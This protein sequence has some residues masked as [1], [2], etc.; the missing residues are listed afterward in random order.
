MKKFVWDTSALINI[1]E[2][3][4]SGY[5]PGYSLMKDLSDGWIPGPYQNIYPAIAVFEVN[6]TVSRMH[7]EG[8]KILRDYYI[9]NESSFIYSIDQQLIYKCN[10]LVV[11]DGFSGLRG[12]DLIFACIAYL[13]KA[14]LVTKDKDFSVIAH[15]VQVIDLNVS[16][17][18][19]KYREQIESGVVEP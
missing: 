6:A 8:K 16:I 9:M 10:E 11:L 17:H 18:S 15:H 4:S 2:P 1:K 19:A 7:R 13:E 5:S 12:A 3:D 14:F